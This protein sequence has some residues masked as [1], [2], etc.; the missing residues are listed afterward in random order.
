MDLYAELGV[1]PQAEPE[2]IRAAF[3]ALA[4]RYHPD[5]Q[6]G[7]SAQMAAK[8]ARINHAYDVLGQADRRRAYD[9][10]C[11]ALPAQRLAPVL[12]ATTSS[13]YRNTVRPF[14]TT[15]DQRGR[16]HAFV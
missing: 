15:Y 1:T 5:R 8:M 6:T 4:R 16:L 7:A 3:R 13:A 10:S 2:V 12:H 11:R 9:A 14:L